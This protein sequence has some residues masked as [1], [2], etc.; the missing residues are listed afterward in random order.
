MTIVIVVLILCVVILIPVGTL[1]KNWVIEAKIPYIED[2]WLVI[3]LFD[4][5][6]WALALLFMVSV[7]MVLY[8]FGPSVKHHFRWLTPGAVFTIVTWIVLGFV[9]R[10]YVDKYGKYDKTY[11]S[12]AGVA[13]LL[14]VFYI[15]AVVLLIGAEINSEI[16]FEVLKIKRGTRDFMGA[17][18]EPQQ[19]LFEEPVEGEKA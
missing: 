6:R 9:F 1:V 19:G 5:V 17:E 4:L 10:F 15:D 7:L 13:I 18:D 3:L 11:G 12:V 14:L 2:G 16:D 8:H